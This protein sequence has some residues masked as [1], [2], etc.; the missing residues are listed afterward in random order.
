VQDLAGY[1]GI[2]MCNSR[3][4]APVLRVYDMMIPQD[5]AFAG[6]I[7]AALDGCPWEEI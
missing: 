7:A 2:I 5:E 4:W 1:D 3:G 6:V